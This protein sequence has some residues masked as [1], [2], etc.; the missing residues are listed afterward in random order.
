MKI[1]RDL[2][3]LVDD[4]WDFK[5]KRLANGDYIASFPDVLSVEMF[6]KLNSVDLA[7]YGLKVKIDKTNIQATTSSM[8]LPTWVRIYGIPDF[9]KMEEVVK[10]LASHAAEPIMVDLASLE[11]ERPVRVHV[12]CR[13]PSKLRGFVEVFFNGMRYKLQ[14]VSEDP[15]GQNQGGQGGPPGNQNGNQDMNKKKGGDSSDKAKPNRQ[16]IG[17]LFSNRGQENSQEESQEDNMEDLI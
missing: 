15:Q 9:A 12:N 7:L 14:F 2:K 13:D 17:D 5:V 8:L 6:S 4:E 3:N 1:D 11:G 16:D 10:D